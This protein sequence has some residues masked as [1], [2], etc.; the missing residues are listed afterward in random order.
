MFIC[1]HIIRGI[2]SEYI[3]V[4]QSETRV[5]ELNYIEL[6]RNTEKECPMK[7]DRNFAWKYAR[8]SNCRSIR[9]D[10]YNYYIIYLYTCNSIRHYLAI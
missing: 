9:L 5:A 1:Y 4:A 8:F 2:C 6:T 3:P 10:G 7:I